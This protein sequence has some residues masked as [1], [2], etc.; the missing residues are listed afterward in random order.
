MR[1]APLLFPLLIP[2]A[3]TCPSDREPSDGPR[4][5]AAKLSDESA[6]AAVTFH[7][8]GVRPRAIAVADFNGDGRP[9]V[10]VANGGDGTVTLLFGDPEGGLG[11]ARSFPAGQDPA[12]IDAV[13]I[14]GDRAVDLVI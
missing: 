1:I 13:D 7:D 10:A 9:D 14:D 12:D 3:L 11:D 5:D 8:V 4:T 6:T 2:A